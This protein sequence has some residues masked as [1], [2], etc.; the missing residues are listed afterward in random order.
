MDRDDIFLSSVGAEDDG[1]EDEE[2][3]DDDTR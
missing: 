2:E 1:A 3:V